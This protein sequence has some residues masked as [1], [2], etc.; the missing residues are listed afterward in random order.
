MI[1]ILRAASKDPLGFFTS[2]A[3]RFGDVVR[4]NAGQHWLYL[5]RNPDDIA[6]VFQ[7]NHANYR[8]SRYYAK[9]I[10]IFGEGMFVAE[11]E[12]WRRKRTLIQPAFH[13][14]KLDALATL[15]TDTGAETIERW[16][17]SAGSGAPLDIAPEMMRA[18]LLVVIKAFF[19]VDFP[20]ETSAMTRAL[21]T[22][23]HAG[24][25]RIWAPFSLPL[26]FPTPE[27]R[28]I[29]EAIATFDRAIFELIEARRRSG[30]AQDDLLSL[31]LDSRFED[32][33]E[34]MSNRE[35]RDELMTMVIA[36]HETTAMAIAWACHLLSRHP[37]AAEK[38]MAEVD[39][40]LAGRTPTVADL[41]NL[42]YTKMVI[43]EGMRIYPPFW[44]MSREAIGDDELGGFHIPAGSVV[45]LCPY[46]V[47]RN[48]AV[49]EDPERFDPERFSAERSRGR[50]KFAYFPFGGGPRICVGSAFAMMEATLLLAMITQRYRMEP[51]PGHP[52]EPQAMISLRPRQ[53]LPM[54]LFARA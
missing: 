7:Q 19:S 49:W 33:G 35:I 1:G 6:Q 18:S 28:R 26:S 9:A 20:G 16:R 10:P 29:R 2:A 53:G 38:L 8:K 31:I 44:S 40:V 11:G 42:A 13:K 52:I 25:R 23:M 21:T 48:P 32:T 47:H 36:G 24:E 50:P 43:Q 5:L 17:A 3:E 41:A 37:E 27:N 46:V 30:V 39:A 54:R 12:A 45:M 51:S 4:F 22:L 15:M 34:P 14:Q